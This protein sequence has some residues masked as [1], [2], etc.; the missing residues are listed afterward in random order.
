MVRPADDFEV[1]LGMT[2]LGYPQ[3]MS[4]MRACH[5]PFRRITTSFCSRVVDWSCDSH[6]TLKAIKISIGI[7]TT[8]QGLVLGSS[9]LRCDMPTGGYHYC[10]RQRK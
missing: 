5:D 10:R 3:L 9:S 7:E 4:L 8:N 6:A 2:V 1:T